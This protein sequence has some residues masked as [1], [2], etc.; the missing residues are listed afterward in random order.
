MIDLR[1]IVIELRTIY[2]RFLLCN[3]VTNIE[4]SAFLAFLRYQFAGAD[5]MRKRRT[6][7][8]LTLAFSCL[9]ICL[10]L[11]LLEVDL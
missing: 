4:I 5:F 7:F 11:A 3:I 2:I 8:L 1:S 10:G 9:K 6:N